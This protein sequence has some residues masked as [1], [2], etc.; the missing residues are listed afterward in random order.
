MKKFLLCI[1]FFI[2]SPVVYGEIP[3]DCWSLN[4]HNQNFI[5]DLPICSYD[6][7]C[8][9]E[10][11]TGETVTIYYMPTL[12]P[13][14]PDISYYGGTG[15]IRVYENGS[16]VGYY[17][18]FGTS[19]THTEEE[20]KYIQTLFLDDVF[21]PSLFSSIV[22]KMYVPSSGGDS[23]G[24]SGS[25]GSETGDSGGDSGSSGSV[26]IDENTVTVNVD[27]TLDLGYP[28]ES[29][30]L[31]DLSHQMP[32]YY[33]E[34]LDP[35]IWEGTYI[36]AYGDWKNASFEFEKEKL[37]KDT[38]DPLSE[39]IPFEKMKQVLG[40]INGSGPLPVIPLRFSPSALCGNNYSDYDTNIDFRAIANNSF[41][42]IL[43]NLAV[44]F[45]YF[46]TGTLILRIFT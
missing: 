40:Y 1:L 45:I 22:K 13:S 38:F 17:I 32:N 18:C 7:D 29:P 3:S 12:F 19:L 25:S 5:D 42:I 4:M 9:I 30:Y 16:I 33:L 23:G 24:D 6:W 21:T 36:S 34:S 43:R 10:S 31:E 37:W 11:G 26:T 28:P 8:F 41:V 46:E 2:W 15:L 27:V 39:K 14:T 20:A 44:F 35:P